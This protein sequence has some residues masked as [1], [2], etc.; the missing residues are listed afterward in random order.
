MFFG[1]ACVYF[2]SISLHFP[3]FH[4]HLTHI[5][6]LLL[7]F[8]PSDAVH[9]VYYS[10]MLLRHLHHHLSQ[11]DQER[12]VRTLTNFT[13][14]HGHVPVPSGL[15]SG[16]PLVTSVELSRPPVTLAPVQRSLAAAIASASSER[17]LFLH[18]PF[19]SKGTNARILLVE[20]EEARVA[21]SLSNPLAVP[22]TIT[23]IALST[24]GVPFEPRAASLVLPPHAKNRQV[25]LAG[26]PMASGMLTVRGVTLTAFNIEREHLVEPPPPPPPGQRGAVKKQRFIDVQVVE[27]LPMLLIRGDEVLR[28]KIALW[29]GERY[30][31]KCLAMWY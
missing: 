18:N 30:E 19:K 10:A 23:K 7:T 14:S 31:I 21:V 9:G 26:R 1:C 25:L 28:R 4:T 2:V 24:S 22:L 27:T 6:A 13:D 5:L 3:S 17:D 20:G 16:L 11:L 29:E 15:L 8:L 12:L